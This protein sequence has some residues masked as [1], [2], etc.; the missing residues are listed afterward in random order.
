MDDWSFLEIIH[1]LSVGIASYNLRAHI[2]SHIPVH[3][4]VIP[5]ENLKSQQQLTEI[6]NWTYKMK[7]KL[8]VKKTKNMIFN[9]SK[10]K[11][12]VTCLSVNE[13]RLEVVIETKLLE[14]ILTSDLK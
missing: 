10:K 9:F 11:Q 14:T 7:M 3:T 5:A 6:N 4:Q 12:F 1:L 13:E 8:N 2:P